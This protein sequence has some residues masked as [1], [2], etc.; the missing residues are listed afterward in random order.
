MTER[1]ASTEFKVTRSKA[2]T[3]DRPLPRPDASAT[4]CASLRL[5][6][7]AGELSSSSLM[8]SFRIKSRGGERER[9]IELEGMRQVMTTALIYNYH[10]TDDIS[11]NKSSSARQFD[12]LLIRS[13]KMK[14]EN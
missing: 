3:N 12:D 6:S 11:T 7:S 4:R 10:A 1:G 2:T 8:T 5:I 9:R 13:I 14:C